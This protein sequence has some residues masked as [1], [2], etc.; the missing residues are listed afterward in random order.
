MIES[1]VLANHDSQIFGCEIL[2]RNAT[3]TM[4]LLN[5]MRVEIWFAPIFVFEFLK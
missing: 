3:K 5:K 4:T 2:Q 1:D